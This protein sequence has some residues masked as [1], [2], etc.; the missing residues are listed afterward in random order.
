M[1]NQKIWLNSHLNFKLTNKNEMR[2]ARYK[3]NDRDAYYHCVTRTVNKEMLLDTRAKEV[4][5]KQLWQMAEF[6][7]V[8]IIT[9]CIMTNHFHVLVKVPEQKQSSDSELVRRFKLLYPK[10]TKYQ[11]MAVD[12]LEANLKQGGKEA[13]KAR[14]RLQAR[15][16]DVSVFM[17]EVK[18]RF[19]IWYNRSHRR[20]GTLWAER[21]KSTL[22]EGNDHAL[23]I[24]AAY[25]DLNPVRA[26]IVKDPKEYRW[27][28]YAEAV[29]GNELARDG[30]ATACEI[31]R[32]R[33]TKDNWKSIS[34]DYRKLIYCKGSSPAPG[35]GG[36][37]S[38]IPEKKW[39]EVL[40]KGGSLPMTSALRCRVRYFTDG[41]ILGSKEY[42]QSY[43]EEHRSEFSRKR[44]KA[45]QPMKGS[46]WGGLCVIRGLRQSVF[47]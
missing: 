11:T 1:T 5:R 30:L 36:A 26:A 27:S 39:R 41:A 34:R 25:I 4:L 22:V 14:K 23:K 38:I 8:E 15:M 42:I 35:K 24:C 46:D 32:N 21:F 29:G 19:S 9:Y 12:V 10:P 45:P 3:I 13:E 17:K 40:S 33:K 16:G 44:K 6:C 31:S 18:Q 7:G 37:G 43:Y 20:I 2:T 47:G 28:G